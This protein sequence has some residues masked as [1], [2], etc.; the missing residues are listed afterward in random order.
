MLQMSEAIAMKLNELEPN[1]AMQEELARNQ[2]EQ[3]N[4]LYRNFNI[5][6]KTSFLQK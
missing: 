6:E 1:F 5:E 3:L 2:E 4:S